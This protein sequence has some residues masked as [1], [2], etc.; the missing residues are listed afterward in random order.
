MNVWVIAELLST[1]IINNN[2]RLVNSCYFWK[3]IRIL[4]KNDSP[5]VEVFMFYFQSKEI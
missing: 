1:F 5:S 2:T 4:Y 3:L